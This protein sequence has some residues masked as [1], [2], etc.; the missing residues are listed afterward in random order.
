LHGRYVFGDFARTFNN[1]GRLFFL[2]GANHHILEFHLAGQ[3]PLGLSVL[4]TGQDAAGELYVLANSTG[5]PFGT[6]GVVLRIAR[7]QGPPGAP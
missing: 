7:G 2:Q 5:V 3:A 1:D 4:G 6:S